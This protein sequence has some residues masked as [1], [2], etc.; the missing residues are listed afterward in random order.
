MRYCVGLLNA[1]PLLKGQVESVTR[2][3]IV[4]KNRIVIEVHAASFRSTRGYSIVAALLDEIA[5]WPTDEASA[6]PDVEIVNAIRPAMATIPGSMLLAASS[7]HARKGS[8]WEAHRRHFGKDDS[9]VLVWQ[10]ATRAMNPSVPQSFIDTHTAED[11]AR[12]S[13][14]YGALFR[15]DVQSFIDREVVER[16]VLSGIRERP[17]SQKFHYRGFADMSGGSR[18]SA[19]LCIAHSDIN[20]QIVS[21]DLIREIKSPHSPEMACEEF[22]KLLKSYGL[23]RVVTDKYG[24]QW[25]IE[26]YRRFSI[27]AEQSADPKGAL[28]VNMLPYLNS[29]RV[30]LLD[31][32]RGINQ[33]C[34]L[35]RRTGHGRGE[36]VDHPPNGFDDVSNA[37]AGAISVCAKSASVDPSLEGDQESEVNI[38]EERRKRR[39]KLGIP[40][41]MSIEA[42]ERLTRV[43][44]SIPREFLTPAD[45]LELERQ[46]QVRLRELRRALGLAEDD[47]SKDQVPQ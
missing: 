5:Y 25:P 17:P 8:L 7:P 9:P 3:A 21:I 27:S 1:V 22:S 42:F 2:E 24:L 31:E 14:E 19:V 41:G 45:H 43:P 35:E 30:E 10:A 47:T 29:L 18:D 23:S 28:Y 26:Q 40:G 13:A 38:D 36:V 34:A 44:L 20:K 46:R 11:P 4:L 33:I 16:C 12:A 39:S 32:P 15:S 6:E 37:I